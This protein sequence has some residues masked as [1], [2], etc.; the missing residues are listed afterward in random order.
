MKFFLSHIFCNKKLVAVT[1]LNFLFEVGHEVR[2]Y[3]SMIRASAILDATSA[4]AHVGRR[5]FLFSF[6]LWHSQATCG[7]N[8]SDGE[9]ILRPD[10]NIGSI[11]RC[12]SMN[13][14]CPPP[15]SHPPYG[16]IPTAPGTNKIAGFVEFR[17]LTRLK[18]IK[19][20]T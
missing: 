17:R 1:M 13:P 15:P 6:G 11:S 16:K 19:G 7:C 14:A 10:S 12:A 3:R 9:F 5:L 20:I 2:I 4:W 18:R 8:L